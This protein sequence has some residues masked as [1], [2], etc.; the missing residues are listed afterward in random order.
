MPL[1]I[2]RRCARA[3]RG[4]PPSC[5]GSIAAREALEREAARAKERIAELARRLVQLGADCE[6]ERQ[7]SADAEAAL[8]RLE[9]ERETLA[10]EAAAGV[11]RRGEVE[12]RAGAAATTLAASEAR[13]GEF[14]AALADL[15]AK[16]SQLE[17]TLRG[18]DERRA[19]LEREH[20][21]VTAGAREAHCRCCPRR[22]SRRPRRCDG[23]RAGS[24][25]RR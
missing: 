12:T 19:K 13:F 6:R 18:C 8:A 23:S 16:R 9:A 17:A 1:P 11:E 20:G 2:C 10:H 24:C 25:R 14:T 15:T 7:L 5:S 3:R 22:R 21:E 4:P